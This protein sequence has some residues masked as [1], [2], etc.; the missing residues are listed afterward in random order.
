M[1]LQIISSNLSCIYLI[2]EGGEKNE[3]EFRGAKKS[4]TDFVPPQ[5]NS[6]WNKKHNILAKFLD[7][8]QSEGQRI[9]FRV[10]SIYHLL[11]SI[12]K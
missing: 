11:L 3:K 4:K 1:M 12:V 5:S 6:P 9:E 2:S 10:T 8:E 7:F